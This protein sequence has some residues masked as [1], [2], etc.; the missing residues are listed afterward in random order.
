MEP[1]EPKDIPYR[2]NGDFHII[3]LRDQVTRNCEAVQTLRGE[4][5]EMSAS[6]QREHANINVAL[7]EHS[8]GLSGIRIAVKTSVWWVASLVT[9]VGL[10]VAGF[11]YLT[12]DAFHY[13]VKRDEELVKQNGI[14]DQRIEHN[15]RQ[16]DRNAA[17]VGAIGSRVERNERDIEHVRGRVRAL[18]QKR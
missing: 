11:S 6:D 16:T 2:R 1:N 13:L 10:L 8:Q 18:E 17:S 7:A 14:Q 15:A 9:V 4:V 5:R 3:A 12:Y